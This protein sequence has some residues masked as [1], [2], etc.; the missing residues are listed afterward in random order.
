MLEY[1]NFFV[2]GSEESYGYLASDRVRDKDA[3]AAV[4][5]F[6]ELAAYLKSQEMIF[7]D[8]LNA[9]NLQHGYYEEKTINIYF[10]GAAGSRRIKN[11]IDS[12]RNDIPKSFGGIEVRSLTDFGKDEIFDAD[13]ERIPSQEFYFLELNNGYSFA[14]RASGTEPKIKF[15]VFGRS[16][17]DDLEKLDEVKATASEVM[18]S[19]LTD[20][21]A[22]ARKRA[23]D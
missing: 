4:V 22:D 18:Q 20:I 6:C 12:Y 3:N 8:Y 15:Y 21:E 11:I 7:S 16:D 17:L 1:S 14:L 23:D 19:L 9:L 13:G 2:F 5:M 10:E